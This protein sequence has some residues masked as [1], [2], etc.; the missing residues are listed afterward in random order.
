MGT[1]RF[2][3]IEVIKSIYGAALHPELWPEALEKMNVLLKSDM[4]VLMSQDLQDPAGGVSASFNVSPDM[5]RSYAEHY[6]SVNPLF[7][8]KQNLLETGAVVTS[9]QMIEDTE[10]VKTEFYEDFLRP[11]GMFYLLAGFLTR[12]SRSVSLVS[13]IRS[14]RKGPFTET[15]VRHL[16]SV[17]CPLQQA[18]E[19]HGRLSAVS[20]AL[21]HIQDGVFL[22]D[23]HDRIQHTN[24]AGE[25]M[26]AEGTAVAADRSR[27]TIGKAHVSRYPITSA[28]GFGG[29][30][31]A[32]FVNAAS[33]LSTPATSFEWT[34]AEARVAMLIAEG[35]SIL[36]IADR[37]K[38]T[39]QTVRNQLKYAMHKAGVHRQA[40]LVALLWR[41]RH[42]SEAHHSRILGQ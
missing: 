12:D 9:S 34:P 23:D 37:S 41:S 3:L 13:T 24:A 35:F 2:G 22:I 14:K 32:V 6:G 11:Q 18:L 17:L 1:R 4:T 36:D 29:A 21:D 25:R 38:L 40:E 20:N 8:S 26:L 5:V 7:S 33:R 27:L 10:L 42:A 31:E 30:T 16:E 28:L 19:L 39:E 15:D